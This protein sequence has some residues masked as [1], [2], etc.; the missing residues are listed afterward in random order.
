MDEKYGK[1][2]RKHDSHEISNTLLYS[3]KNNMAE[4][5]NRVRNFTCEG[6]VTYTIAN[7][8]IFFNKIVTRTQRCLVGLT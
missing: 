6:V 4:F 1:V 8:I 7:P 3:Y 2:E 5:Y